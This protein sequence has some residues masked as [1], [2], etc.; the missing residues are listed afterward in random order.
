MSSSA[1]GMLLERLLWPVPRIRWEA[2]R[3]LARL[4]RE[5]NEDATLGLL[6]WIS[7][8][9]LESEVVAGLC[10]I[11]AFDLRAHFEFE[12][13]TQAVQVHSLLSDWILRKN[14]RPHADLS[15]SRYSVSPSKPAPLSAYD[16]TKFQ[17]NRK[18]NIPPIFAGTLAELE[19]RV[20]YPFCERWEHEW[21]WLQTTNPRPQPKPLRLYQRGSRER[22]GLYHQGQRELYVS[23]FLRTLAGAVKAGKMPHD[24]AEYCALMAITMNE[25]LADLSPIDRPDWTQNL[26]SVSEGDTKETA[27][28]LWLNAGNTAKLGEEPIAL[29]AIDAG[30]KGFVEFEIAMVFGASGFTDGPALVEDPHYFPVGDDPGRIA[31]PVY[32]DWLSAGAE[33]TNRPYRMA[34]GFVPEPLGSLH[35]ELGFNIRLLA[36]NFLPKRAKVRCSPTEVIL[37]VDGEA[38]SRWIHW[39]ANWEPTV[40]EGLNSYIGSLSTASKGSLDMLHN[41]SGM[42]TACLVRVRRGI[43]PDS[44]L[45]LESTTETFWM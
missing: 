19:K 29:R 3:S 42:E 25:G 30:S 8:R 33:L 26:L 1:L 16:A 13:V 41:S 23:A 20:L 9:H 10:I 31:G 24:V 43:R 6:D 40:E 7:R 14:F 28:A 5:G 15:P 34:H 11:D 2:G 32:P 17:R 45:E 39:Y 44:Y 36:P 22:V 18:S 27:R 12:D 37:D 4:I 21:R 38:V 35:V